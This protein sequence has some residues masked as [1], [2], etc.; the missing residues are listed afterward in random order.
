MTTT[1]PASVEPT[2]DPALVRTAGA[3]SS[4]RRMSW[5]AVIAGTVIAVVVQLVLSL[6]GA[7]VGFSTIDP[8]RYNGS[9]DAASFGIGVAIWW[10][11]TSI[12]AL[13][14][15]GWVAGHVA[16][17]PDKTDGM[18][19]GLLAWALAT[20]FTAYLLASAIGSVVGG[21]ASAVGAAARVAGSGIAAAA[22]PVTDMAQQ[23]LEASGISLDDI[24]SEAR[25]LLAQT[26]VPA[27]QPAA[28]ANTASAAAA[29]LTNAT[30]TA[31]S[32]GESMVQDLQK[33]LQSII[34][35]GKTVVDKADR[36]AL[37][38]VVMARANISR[39]EA[40]QRVS[41]W[42]DSYEKAAATLE[43]KKAEAVANAKQAADAA[44]RASSQ[45]A[46]GAAFALILGAI[47]AAVGG[48]S[49][50]SRSDRIGTVRRGAY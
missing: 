5:G 9:P 45:A 33:A 7:G 50:R 41:A 39:P 6:I 42:A 12:V 47:A 27:L 32:N 19:H 31:G 23:K 26:G 13:Y 34:S 10:A 40:E 37:V 17:S 46:L 16:A 20:I 22:G 29:D 28:I 11:V 4:F 30:A 43:Q 2:V 24:R 18:L 8:L 36:D 21:A 48:M 14:V 15:G 44:A 1:Y 3:A 25:K 49:A 35:S 38:N